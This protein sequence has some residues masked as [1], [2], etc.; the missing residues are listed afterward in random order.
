M[1]TAALSF[2]VEQVVGSHSSGCV[3][4]AERHEEGGELG[5]VRKGRSIATVTEDACLRTLVETACN[6]TLREKN[7]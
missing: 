2:L 4:E 1:N 7:E 6:S 3:G 5:V